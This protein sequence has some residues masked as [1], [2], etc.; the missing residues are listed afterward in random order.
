MFDESTKIID[1]KAL[2]DNRVDKA[3]ML[4]AHSRTMIMMFEAT[5]ELRYLDQSVS[6]LLSADNLIEAG[7]VRPLGVLQSKAA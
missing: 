4:R 5:G 7:F 1:M 3:R 2:I 6:D